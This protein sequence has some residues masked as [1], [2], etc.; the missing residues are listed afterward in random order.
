[1]IVRWIGRAQLRSLRIQYTALVQACAG[2]P[3]GSSAAAALL[4]CS[5][6]AATRARAAAAVC[7]SSSS[8]RFEQLSKPRAAPSP[9]AIKRSS[10]ELDAAPA[11]AAGAGAAAAS[12]STLPTLAISS[13]T[14]VI[15]SPQ[16]STGMCFSSAR[17]LR[18]RAK[19]HRADAAASTTG[20]SAKCHCSAMTSAC[21]APSACNASSTSSG[22][23][24][25]SLSK[26]PV[27]AQAKRGN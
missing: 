2:K 9:V 21:T 16:N 4:H 10:G 15:S 8:R 5:T 3:A 11:V 27:P 22:A 23:P 14:P 12:A 26:M 18:T 7:S 25:A 17:M 13:A 19:L 6:A 1:M 20:A 24:A